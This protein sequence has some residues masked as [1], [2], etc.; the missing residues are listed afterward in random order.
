MKFC[1]NMQMVVHLSDPE[2][3]PF[4]VDYVMLKVSLQLIS[5]VYF[6]VENMNIVIQNTV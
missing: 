1:E 3:A 4:W 2:W 6:L 5:N